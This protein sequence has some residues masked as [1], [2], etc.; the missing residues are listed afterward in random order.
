LELKD[1]DENLY[2]KVTSLF[3]TSEENL[4][5]IVRDAIEYRFTNEELQDIS[6]ESYVEFY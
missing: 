3:Y 4:T 2:E 5:N 1:K 6:Y